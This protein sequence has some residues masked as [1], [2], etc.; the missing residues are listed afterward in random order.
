MHTLLQ[1]KAALRVQARARRDA[2]PDAERARESAALCALLAEHPAFLQSDLLLTFSPVRGEVDLTALAVLAHA[3]GKQVAY[4]RCE[5]KEMLFYLCAPH[6][7]TNGRFGIPAPPPDAPRAL[8]TART[9]CLLPALAAAKDGGR[10]GYGGGFY[11]RFLPT[12][13]GISILPI[14][15]ALLFDTLPQEPTDRKP[16]WILTEK[17][18]AYRA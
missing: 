5:G 7:L 14:Y 13:A 10:L 1:E 15:Q 2:L 6:A 16:D 8:P 9:L 3:S 4:P 17:G 11:D 18:V 12:F